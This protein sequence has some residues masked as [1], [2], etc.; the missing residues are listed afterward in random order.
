MEGYVQRVDKI[1]YMP[2]SEKSCILS[3]ITC[4]EDAGPGMDAGFISSHAN[5]SGAGMDA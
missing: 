5:S 2:R 3:E 4:G 1:S